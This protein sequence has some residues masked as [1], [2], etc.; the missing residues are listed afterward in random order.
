VSYL[1]LLCFYKIEITYW[2]REIYFNIYLYNCFMQIDITRYK[3]I[4][5]LIIIYITINYT[6]CI[7]RTVNY[8]SCNYISMYYNYI[9][10]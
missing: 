4:V 1:A 2:L 3:S 7:F 6:W 5:T 8:N 9:F 10:I